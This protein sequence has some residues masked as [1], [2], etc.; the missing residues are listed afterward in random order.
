MGAGHDRSRV[1]TRGEPAPGTQSI[2]RAFALLRMVATGGDSGLGLSE[3]AALSGLP[4]PTAHRILSALVAEGLIEQRARTRRYTLGVE[5]Q[6]LALSRTARSPLVRFAEPRLQDVAAAIGDT[7]FLTLRSGLDT[8]CVARR[9]GPYP[10][11]VLVLNVGDRR[12]L[13]VSSAGV[14]I[15]ACLPDEDAAELLA[16]NALRLRS[17]GVAVE[18]ALAAVRKARESGRALRTPGLVPG[19]RALSV[20]IRA[21]GGDAAGALTVAAV[22]RRLQP[23]RFDDVTDTLRRFAG[24]CEAILSRPEAA[25]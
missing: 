20:P 22:S 7:L 11:Q 24:S 5:V 9:L 2:G 16:E 15:L 14:A 18:G 6:F 25:S 13:G 3:V 8:I 17:R 21:P 4:R 10:I 12:P 19:T 1:R 23:G